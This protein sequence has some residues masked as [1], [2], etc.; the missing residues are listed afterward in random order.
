MHTLIVRQHPDE[1]AYVMNHAED[2]FLIV[3]DV[4]LD[5]WQQVKSRVHCERIIVV[6]HGKGLPSG[7]ESY[8]A[9]LEE[10]GDDSQYPDL[11]EDDAAAMCYASGTTGRP[12]GVLYSHR[13]IALHSLAS[14]M[15]DHFNI[16]R[17]HMVL[18]V[19]SMHH[20]NAWGLPYSAVMNGSKLVLPGRNLQP[21][22]LLDIIQAE[23]VTLA[24]G[25]PTIWMGILDA[26]K[27]TQ[28]VGTLRTSCA[29]SSG[30]QQLP[31]RCSAGSTSAAFKPF[32]PGE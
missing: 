32:K 1:L 27:R 18:P 2:R 22:A 17:H 26:P 28:A 19:V 12:K 15:P 14:S 8:E 23:Q 5:V 30:V 7:T 3:E 29:F 13:S 10:A 16:S 25:V 4:L 9:F 21:A 6:D 31:N 24:A 11:E 20:V